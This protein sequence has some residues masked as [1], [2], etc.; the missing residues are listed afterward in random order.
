MS[1]RMV[2]EVE[3][4]QEHLRGAVRLLDERDGSALDP[5]AR[6][7][8]TLL[9]EELLRYRAEGLFPMNH[10]FDGRRPTFVD[11]H[12]TRCAMAHLM[13]LGG[14]GDLVA[15]VAQHANH[16]YVEELAA[17]P[18]FVAWLG[19]AGL[20]VEEAARIQPGYDHC[21]SAAYCLCQSLS[22][23]PSPAAAA[24]VATIVPSDAGPELRGVVETIFGTTSIAVGDELRLR[25]QLAVNGKA[26][27]SAQVGDRVFVPIPAAPQTSYMFLTKVDASGDV[28]GGCNLYDPGFGTVTALGPLQAAELAAVRSTGSWAACRSALGAKDVCFDACPAAR[29]SDAGGVCVYG[30]GYLPDGGTSGAPDAGTT[31]TVDAGTVVG[32]DAGLDSITDASTGGRAEKP[33]STVPGDAPVV[34][35]ST[36]GGLNVAGGG[37]CSTSAGAA[38]TSV[39]VL[40]AV[41]GALL[42]RQARR[43]A[44]R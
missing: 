44:R 35:A 40:L 25:T 14:A 38:P 18:R 31:A 10:D 42:A 32:T 24:V 20:T 3:R 5:A 13:E 29:D 11:E 23:T 43:R 12:G 1:T 26:G 37:T 16:A 19:A 39:A 34:S 8:R 2:G 6:I 9:R 17:D 33:E 22:F 28:G 30:I 7:T 27:I 36:P 4:I 41:A 21:Y 15:E